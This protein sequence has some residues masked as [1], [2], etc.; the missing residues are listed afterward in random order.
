MTESCL[1]RPVDGRGHRDVRGLLRPFG[2]AVDLD[3]L[4][5]Q[6]HHSSQDEPNK[7][8]HEENPVV[9]GGPAALT[10]GG[11]ARLSH[12][13]AASGRGHLAGQ[14]PGQGQEDRGHIPDTLHFG[15]STVFLGAC[16]KG[17]F[18]R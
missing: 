3:P 13:A 6:K 9:D 11:S 5:H 7:G 15:S 2:L 1:L 18:M 8:E 17:C 4:A 14:D 10:E 16:S 12:R